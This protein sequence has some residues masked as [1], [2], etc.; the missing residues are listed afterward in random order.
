MAETEGQSAPLNLEL[1]E[2]NKQKALDMIRIQLDKCG[3]LDDSE[4]LFKLEQL[5]KSL[6]MVQVQ[7]RMDRSSDDN[8]KMS[9][10]EQALNDIYIELKNKIY[11]I[12]TI[13]N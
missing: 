13:K 2:E 10:R 4:T 5:L 12:K 9:P 11:N 6:E 1:L 8:S 7:L 3:S